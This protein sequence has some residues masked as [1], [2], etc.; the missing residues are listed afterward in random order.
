MAIYRKSLSTSFGR[1]VVEANELGLS[2]VVF[3]KNSVQLY[4][5]SNTSAIIQQA[6]RELRAYFSG[7]TYDFSQLTYDFSELSKF[8]EKILRVLLQAPVKLISYGELANL[9][10]SPGSSRAVGT[11]M[12]KNPFPIFIPCHRVVLAD[13]SIGQYAYGVGWK[14]RLLDHEKLAC[15][16]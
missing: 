12:N 7:E 5:T 4:D 6:V 11:V 1:F 9:A 10:A 3:P 16:A 8:Q 15:L 14:K 13:G 2:R